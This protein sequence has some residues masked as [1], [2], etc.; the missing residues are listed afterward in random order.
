MPPL[1]PVKPKPSPRRQ[2]PSA[3]S[4]AEPGTEIASPRLHDTR[5]RSIPPCS[6]AP[7]REHGHTT[8]A[9]TIPRRRPCSAAFVCAHHL[10]PCAPHPIDRVGPVSP[11]PKPRRQRPPLPE[12]HHLFPVLCQ[13]QP[14]TDWF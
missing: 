3:P 10:P 8:T 14:G 9:A 12:S 5:A 2:P 11:R 7:H 13:V 4:P 1:P 6:P